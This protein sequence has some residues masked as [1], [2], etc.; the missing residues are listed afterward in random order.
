MFLPL[1]VFRTQSKGWGLRADVGT[2]AGA[3]ICSYERVL[4]SH[5]EAVRGCCV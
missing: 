2:P 5:E 3:F 4:L 1:E